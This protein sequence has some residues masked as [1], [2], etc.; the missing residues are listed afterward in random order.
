[1]TNTEVSFLLWGCGAL[2]GILSFIGALAV[3]Q[4]MHMAT[5]INEIKIT[6]AK[7]DTQHI[8]LEKRVHRLE[9]RNQ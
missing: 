7:V 5:D 9:R 8:E 2:L 1:M 3:K 6:I 4:L